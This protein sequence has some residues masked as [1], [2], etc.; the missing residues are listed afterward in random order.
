MAQVD[1][2]IRMLDVHTPEDERERADLELMQRHARALAQP[3]SRK[4][5]TAHFTGSAVVVTPDGERVCMLHHAK[6]NRWLQPGGHAD[7]ADGGDMARTALREAAEETG[8]EVTLHPVAPAPL[9]V[10]VHTIPARKD[11]PEHA[12]L[13]VRFLVVAKNPE[14]L[15]HDPAESH[16]ARWL[17]FSDALKCADEAPLRRLL[18]KAQRA[19]RGQP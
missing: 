3:F 9:D 18:L 19:V 14:A 10:D 2:L 1:S 11:E 12:H 15:A 7:E 4:E 8:C 13:D 16:G 5:Q 17:P 6:L